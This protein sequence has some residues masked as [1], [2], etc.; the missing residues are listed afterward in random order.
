MY[1]PKHLSHANGNLL[2][3][4]KRAWLARTKET[5]IAM[6]IE[7]K[8]D[9]I[10]EFRRTYDLAKVKATHQRAFHALRDGGGG[11]ELVADDIG[12]SNG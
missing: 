8:V 3:S 4:E 9:R 1:P 10:D 6:D 12:D 7:R 5:L 2:C 11:V